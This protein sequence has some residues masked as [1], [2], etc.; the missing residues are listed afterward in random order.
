MSTIVA[1]RFESFADAERAARG[2][3]GHGFSVW[4]VSIFTIGTPQA[5]EQLGRPPGVLLAARVEPER[6]QTAAELIRLEGGRELEQAEGQWENGRW[7]DFD[8][9]GTPRPL[10]ETAPHERAG[11]LGE[12][13]LNPTGNEDPGSEIDQSVRQDEDRHGG[14]AG[15]G[16]GANGERDL[17]VLLT[18]GQHTTTH[19]GVSKGDEARMQGQRAGEPRQQGATGETPPAG[20]GAG[21]GASQGQFQDQGQGQGQGQDQS[22]GQSQPE[23]HGRHPA[24]QQPREAW[25][26]APSHRQPGEKDNEPE[27]VRGAT[28]TPEPSGPNDTFR[29]IR[30]GQFP[31]GVGEGDLR[32]PG[33]TTP[34]APKV[35]N[36]S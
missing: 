35:D 34:D 19:E 8:P 28:T 31:P 27:L 24:E 13:A 16:A 5:A 32:D 10:Q 7:T 36:R 15:T 2:L 17:G 21:Q 33:S 3:Y 25:E 1:G 11:Q 29:Q 6:L 23:S 22:Q 9:L 26:S 30:R 4:D 18:P 20:Q 12:G 14:Q